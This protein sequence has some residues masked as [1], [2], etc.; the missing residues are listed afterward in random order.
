MSNQVAVM[1]KRLS[2]ATADLDSII[3]STIMP[4]SKKV[5]VTNEQ[6]VSFMAV[7]NEYQLN[8]LVKEIYAFPA[9]GGGIQPVVSIDGW[10][11]IITKHPDFDGMEFIDE[12]DGNGEPISTTC[13]IYRK[14]LSRP[15]TATEYLAEC[16]MN[17]DVW[18]KYPRRMLRHKATIQ[19]GRYAFGISGIIDPDEA[20]RFAV[21]KVIEKDVTPSVKQNIIEQAAVEEAPDRQA[22]FDECCEAMENAAHPGELQE[23]FGAGWKALKAIAAGNELKSI[24]EIYE[25]AKAKF[26]A[27]E[28]A[29]E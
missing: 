29:S 27:L 21:A 1:A 23:A 7:A 19:C 2:I 20:D 9:K 8:P 15:I 3:K 14:S 12:I 6:F 10:I 22:I 4:D 5:T 24:Q 28:K 25:E 11:K 13:K 18:R 26:E 16:R 17:T